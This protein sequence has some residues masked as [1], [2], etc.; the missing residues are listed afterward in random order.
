MTWIVATAR[1]RARYELPSRCPVC[2]NPNHMHANRQGSVYHREII[3][4]CDACGK[5][6][7]E[8]ILVRETTVY[9]S[10]KE[11]A[12]TAALPIA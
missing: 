9:D 1:G 6:R 12:A 3:E 11:Q 2:K 8:F 7:R 4:R 5:H 10:P